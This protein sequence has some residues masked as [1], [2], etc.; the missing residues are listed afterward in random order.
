[1]PLSADAQA[2]LEL[3]LAKGQTYGDLAGLL[4][5]SADEVR[6]R[7]RAAVTELADGEDPDRNVALTDWL[8]GQADPIGRAEAARHLREDPDDNRLAA[9]L[10]ERL[11]A[12]APG[13][14]LPRLPGAP[15]GGMRIGRAKAPKPAPASASASESPPGVTDRL[16]SLSPQQTR[17]LVG[18]ASAAVLMIV[19]VLAV[20]GAFSGS[21]DEEPGSTAV[22]ETSTTDEAPG[23]SVDVELKAA[24]DS[25]ASGTFRLGVTNGT[26]PYIDL[27][28]DDL[29]P[30]P[31]GSVYLIWF[32]Q[33]EQSG[34]PYQEVRVMANGTVNERYSLPQ[35]LL[36]AML[37]SQSVDVWIS[38]RTEV[39]K[40]VADA[41]EKA[42]LVKVPGERVLTADVRPIAQAAGVAAA[43]GQDEG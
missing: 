1:M 27:A 28:V 31:S 6:S 34:Y 8:L 7:A 21:E 14:D 36:S 41:L 23:E 38:P 15:A 40:L 20:T 43:A 13:A 32:M 3:I 17:L 24:G 16:S 29:Q 19:V 2:L 39:Q 37:S 5:V 25:D 22:A 42:S 35:E 12:V 33:D 11:A 4:G 9:E 10:L 18:L 26:Q 30:P